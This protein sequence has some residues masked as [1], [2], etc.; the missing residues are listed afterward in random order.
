MRGAVSSHQTGPVGT[1]SLIWGEPRRLRTLAG[2]ATCSGCV[3]RHLSRLLDRLNDSRFTECCGVESTALGYS[4]SR[5]TIA[6]IVTHCLPPLSLRPSLH[7][8]SVLRVTQ[9]G[10]QPR[11]SRPCNSEPPRSCGSAPSREHLLTLIPSTSPFYLSTA[12]HNNTRLG[13]TECPPHLHQ[14]GVIAVVVTAGIDRSWLNEEAE[15]QLLRGGRVLE[16]RGAGGTQARGTSSASPQ[17]A[18]SSRQGLQRQSHESVL[19]SLSTG[20]A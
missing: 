8:D 12:R 5:P 15:R 7:C 20:P 3:T 9:Q 13:H 19:R 18:P 4:P 17:S 11:C 10:G 16:L 1:S 6:R 14:R 2:M